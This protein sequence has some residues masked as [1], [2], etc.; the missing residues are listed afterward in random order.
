VNTNSAGESPIKIYLLAQN[1]LVREVIVRLFRKRSGLTVAG[2]SHERTGAL[3]ELAVTPCDVLLLD[4]LETLRAAEQRAEAAECLRKIKVMLFGMEEDPEC[5]L[6]AVRL[7]ACGYLL[8]DASP[9]EII[10]AVRGVAQGEAIC[11]P[12]LCKSLFEYVSN[13]FLL[14]SGKVEQRGRPANDLTCRQRQLMTLVAKGMTNKEIAASLQLSEFTVKNHIQRIMAHLQTD[15]R[16]A[17]VDVIRAGGFFL[18]AQ[19]DHARDRLQTGAERQREFAALPKDP[20]LIRAVSW[21][22]G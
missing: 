19:A 10:A 7:G 13:K 22:R 20:H 17:A 4:S 2:A 21:M 6:Q 9:T 1:R 16:H 15:S 14:H 8:N 3:E 11:P 18:S 5:F 12:Q